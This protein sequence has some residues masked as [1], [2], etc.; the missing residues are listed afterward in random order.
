MAFFIP[1]LL[2]MR[3]ARYSRLAIVWVAM[4][5]VLFGLVLPAILCRH[6]PRCARKGFFIVCP[7]AIGTPKLRLYC[8]EPVS[9]AAMSITAISGGGRACWGK[10]PSRTG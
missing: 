4:A 6:C 5:E 2:R 10:K 8:H 3:A 1:A 9:R 7:S